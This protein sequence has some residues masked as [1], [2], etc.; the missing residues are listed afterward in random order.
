MYRASCFLA[1]LILTLS[2]FAQV[3]DQRQERIQIN[4]DSGDY[5]MRTGIQELRGNVRIAQG[6]LVV[7]ADEGRA[8]NV[9]GQ[10]QRVEL[11]GAPTTWRM[12]M[13]DGTETRGRSEQI[14]YDLTSDQI[15]MIDDARI[16]DA[17]G[18]F[19]GATLTYNLVT[20]RIEGAGG[21]ELVIEPGERRT[22]QDSTP[23]PD[24]DGDGEN[25]PNDEPP[26]DPEA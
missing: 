26:P 17:Q 2:A 1:G 14:I 9:D 16:Q 8:Y 6:E 25:N 15:T 11:F 5:D 22:R 7:E 4:A 20:E 3:P 19:A 24:E 12:V 10:W 18:T 21:V 13:E 23:P